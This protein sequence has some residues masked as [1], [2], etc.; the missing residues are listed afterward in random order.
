M[1]RMKVVFRAHITRPFGFS[2]SGQKLAFSYTHTRGC[3]DHT[4]ERLQEK[5]RKTGPI[6]I[7]M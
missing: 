7:D 5:P 2:M 4:T 6:E 3:H 1:Y